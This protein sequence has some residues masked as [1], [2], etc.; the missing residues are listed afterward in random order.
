VEEPKITEPAR[1]LN[2]VRKA[3]DTNDA[4]QIDELC[5]G[6]LKRK[7]NEHGICGDVANDLLSSVVKLLDI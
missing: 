4:A 5:I 2:Q 6:W 3:A 7:S 1:F